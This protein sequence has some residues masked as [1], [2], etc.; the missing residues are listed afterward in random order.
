MKKRLKATPEMI[1]CLLLLTLI[2]Y[3]SLGIVFRESS[4]ITRSIISIVA[5][6]LFFFAYQRSLSTFFLTALVGFSTFIS[7]GISFGKPYIGSSPWQL[8]IILGP[9]VIFILALI[10]TLA[11]WYL[12]EKIP[13]VDKFPLILLLVFIINWLILGFHVSFWDDWKLENYLTIPFLLLLYFSHRWFRF[14]Q[15]SYGLIYAFLMLHVIGAHYTYAEVPLGFW[16]KDFFNMARNHYDR[17]VHFSFGL[18]LAYPMREI[19]KRIGNV[20]GLWAFYVPI[21]F[22]LASSAIFEILEMIAALVYGGD[23]GIAYLGTQGDV[24]DPIMD[25]TVAGVGSILVMFI[26]VLVIVYYDRKGFWK[27]FK[28][29]LSVKQTAVLG[30]KA[31]SELELK[32]RR[33]GKRGD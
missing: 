25:M 19:A 9:F 31:L 7:L 2:S 13:H 18:L 16:L 24:W 29:S 26:V 4:F 15:L 30:E 14:S 17:I 28:E 11:A 22:V 32:K 6:T 21:E 5:L 27:E 23:L 12:Y 20:R 1:F 3:F 10:V 33:K 8:P